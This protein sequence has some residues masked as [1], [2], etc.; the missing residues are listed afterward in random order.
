MASPVESAIQIARTAFASGRTK[1]VH[2]RRQQIRQLLRMVE[3]NEQNFIETLTGDLRKPKFETILVETDFVA[4]DCRT[5]LQQLHDNTRDQHQEKN[6]V[7]LLDGVFVRPEPYGVVLIIGTWN[8]PLM[9]TLCP[10]LGAIAAGNCA[11]VKCN[12]LAPLTGAL[13]QKLSSQYLDR[14]CFHVL[15]GDTQVNIE[16][17]QHRFDY[18]FFTGSRR[19][20]KLVHQSAAQHLTPVTLELGGKSPV[21]VDEHLD[22]RSLHY[23]ARRLLWG[24]MMN[25]GQ[26][27]VAPDYLLVHERVHDRFLDQLTRVFAHEFFVGHRVAGNE[28]EFDFQA[29]NNDLQGSFVNSVGNIANRQHFE[30]LAALLQS[31]RGKSIRFDFGR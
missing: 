1:D 4:N 31:T 8:Y 15:N 22:E 21:Y 16:L 12:E 17:L 28:L 24:K 20:G 13:L 10:L 30:R 19:V 7:S 25:S 9:V 14:E 5:H 29:N 23:A 2:F 27:C 6:L 26:T 11:V 3:E 18:I